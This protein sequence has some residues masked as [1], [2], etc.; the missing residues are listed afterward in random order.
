MTTRTI[1]IQEMRDRMLARG[2]AVV[3]EQ[4]DWQKAISVP[5]NRQLLGLIASHAPRSVT[6]L[7][8]I[9]GRAQPNVSRSLAQLVKSG[10]VELHQD[11]RT[12]APLL[13]SLACEK[14]DALQIAPGRASD[15]AA[16]TQE[17][18][19]M[20]SV[21]LD[22]AGDGLRGSLVAE[23]LL[24]DQSQPVVAERHGDLAALAREWLNDWWRMLY[25]T[26]SDY[27]LCDLRLRLAQNSRNVTVLA[28]SYGQRI[29][30]TARANDDLGGIALR[31]DCAR[32][33]I[34][35][36]ERVLLDGVLQPL[37]A[38]LKARNIYDHPL[39]GLLSRLI[40][41]R[42]DPAEAEFCRTAGALGLAPYELDDAASGHVRELIERL[43]GEEARLDFASALLA[44]ELAS[45]WEWVSSELSRVEDRNVLPGLSEQV[46]ACSAVRT[47]IAGLLPKYRGIELA[48]QLRTNL[49]L[50]TE[51]A[52]GGVAG[53][54]RLLGAPDFEPSGEAP[55]YLLGFQE[56][57]RDGP[58]VVV[59]VREGFPAAFL[60]GRAI[61]D[62]L[63]F[64]DHSA[65]IADIY[66]DRQALGRAFAAEFLAP[67]SAVVAMVE[68]E[69]LSENR[70]ARHF[71]APLAVI[72]HQRE[73]N[74]T[75]RAHRG[76]R[77]FPEA[78]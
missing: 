57:R 23:L 18:T 14:V 37:S 19:A 9:A 30:L 20:F 6:E 46:A 63:A 8:D 68:R 3:A 15:G 61:G 26:D 12:S 25:R 65:C 41:S 55:G 51:Q 45:G 7:A 36:F 67:A 34:D 13:T 52:L 62:F 31:R 4:L 21:R 49:Q 50:E 58:T 48:K 60:L 5:G 44:D 27:R 43:P 59:G 66:T 29:E 39:H 42:S 32:F 74:A 54:A 76:Q 53:I 2:R 56:R 10:L 40:E 28:K 69:G 17:P 1:S 16:I 78:V 35:A 22:G 64:G 33:Q 70:V 72:R 77:R 47:R 73:N 24:R 75:R 71:G 11:G 38:S